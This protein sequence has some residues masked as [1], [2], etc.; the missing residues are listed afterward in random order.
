MVFPD[1]ALALTPLNSAVQLLLKRAVLA[2]E[3]FAFRASNTL[4]LA[5]IDFRLDRYVLLCLCA[6]ARRIAERLKIALGMSA[7]INK[8]NDVIAGPLS[9]FEFAGAFCASPSK[10]LEQPYLH[11]WRNSRIWRAT[12]PFI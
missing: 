11:P 10:A 8:R 4:A 12:D 6:V 3:K 9:W 7:A 5:Q 1:I 2:G